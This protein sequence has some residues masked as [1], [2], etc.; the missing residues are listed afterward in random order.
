MDYR[1]IGTSDLKASVLSLG[2]YQ[3][4]Q[5]MEYA[6]IVALIRQA[7]DAGVTL[8]DVAHYRTA[9]HTEV[10]VGRALLDAGL[11]RDDFLIMD[12]IWWYDSNDPD[13]ETQLDRLLFRLG[14]DHLDVVTCYGMRPGRDDPAET[15]RLVAGFV[16]KG[17][18]R[19]WGG[20]N[21]S[22]ADLRIAHETCVAENLP[23]PQIVQSKYNIARRRVVE[24]PEYSALRD[25]TGISIHASDALEG[26]IL[27]GKLNS[28]RKLGRDPGNIREEIIAM[29]P[30]L[31]EIAGDFNC[32]MA[33][34]AIA[35][36]IANPQTASL[37]FGASNSEQLKDNL[38]AVE[39]SRKHGADIRE[40]LKDMGVEGHGFDLPPNHASPLAAD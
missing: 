32:T 36:C 5:R 10:V 16:T 12:K 11:Q 21:W 30:R 24:S 40:A 23:G 8:F 18:A 26:G 1:T 31:R 38:G 22:A 27:A 34:L 13:L 29:V 2:S 14:M 39:V 3:T 19:A 15:A 6:D 37:L 9:P 28:E 20:L 33:Q 35:F 17:K 25:E 4:Y 7:A